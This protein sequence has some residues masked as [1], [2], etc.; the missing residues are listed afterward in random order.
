MCD[1][2]QRACESKPEVGPR[3][4]KLA[5]QNYIDRRVVV[6]EARRRSEAELW[7]AKS[8]LPVQFSNRFLDD[9]NALQVWLLK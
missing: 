8:P 5:Y 7:R 3:P 2:P 6:S 1:F 4:T 9:L